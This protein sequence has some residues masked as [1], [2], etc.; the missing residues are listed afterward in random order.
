M[1]T[2]ESFTN[3]QCR[4]IKWDSEERNLKIEVTPNGGL[5]K[6]VKL[7]FTVRI[8]TRLSITMSIKHNDELSWIVHHN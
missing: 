8:L 6:D 4:V 1:K 3:G 2:L 7:P 5:Y